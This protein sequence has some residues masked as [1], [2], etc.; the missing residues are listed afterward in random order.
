MSTFDPVTLFFIL[1]ETF[2]VW[3]W[4][5]LATAL[6]LLAGIVSALVKLRRARCPVATPIWM[7]V[8]A[9]LVAAMGF[10]FAVSIW[11]LADPSALSGPLDYVAILVA[12]LPG[13]IVAALVFMLAARRCHAPIPS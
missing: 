6:A 12:L 7:A 2:G 8:A 13:A 11:T 1:Y 5:L 4:V 3:L 9:G 10:T